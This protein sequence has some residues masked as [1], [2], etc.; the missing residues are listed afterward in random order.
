MSARWKNF[1]IG[2]SIAA[3]LVLLGGFNATK[4]RILVVNSAAEDSIWSRKIKEGINNVLERNRRPLNVDYTY[5]VLDEAAPRRTREVEDAELQRT[6]AR[7]KPDIII[8]VD[9][10]ANALV[11]PLYAGKN[12]PR[13]IYVS[14]DRPPSAYGYAGAPNVSGIADR[15]PLKALR[16]FADDLDAGRPK[17]IAVLG[18]ESET[19][20]AE[21]EQV[22]EFDWAP[23]R[24]TAAAVVGTM[25]A[26]E[27]FLRTADADILLVLDTEDLPR[28]GTDPALV[29]TGEIIRWTEKNSP[30]LPVGTHV[31]HGEEG[32]AVSFSPPPDDYGEK[33]MELAIDWLDERTTPGAPPPVESSSFEVAI[34]QGLLRE[35]GFALP[36]IYIEAARENGTLYP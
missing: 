3:F 21:L 24:V 25:E 4:P 34:R 10:E 5:L 23:H 36:P 35:R 1:L 6:L 7:V 8:A 22:R 16:D 19:G 27:N 32:G 17:K 31:R 9:D 15:L 26:W 29:S 28:S 33:A 11:A 13:I 14:I 30:A 18:V 12:S 2:A 20:L